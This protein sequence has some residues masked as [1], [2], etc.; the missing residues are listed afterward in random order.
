M[1]IVWFIAVETSAQ[2]EP[3]ITTFILIRHAEKMSDASNDP[4]LTPEGIARAHKIA[5]ILGKTN[6]AAIYSTRYK[7]TTNTI[8]PLAKNKGLEVQIYEPMKPAAIENMLQ[9]HRGG[10][11]VI[12]GHS[13]TIPWTANQLIG[14]DE[15]KTF[16]DNDYGNLLVISVVEKGKIASVTWLNF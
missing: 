8:A 1:L 15:F 10:T 9:R 2:P 13:N 5:A 12:S 16:E 7:R 3:S 11:I 6:V 4:D 14:K